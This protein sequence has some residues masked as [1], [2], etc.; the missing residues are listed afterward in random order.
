MLKIFS[1]FHHT[2]RLNFIINIVRLVY[3]S[4]LIIGVFFFSHDLAAQ[5]FTN[6]VEY[7]NYIV[8]EQVKVVSQNVNYLSYSVHSDDVRLVDEKRLDLIAQLLKSSQKLVSMGGYEG[9][10]RLRDEA[11]AVMDL[12]LE[13]FNVDL[14][15]IA[16]L[17]QSS[18]E[19]Y[20][21]METYF[22]TL[23]SVEAK[24]NQAG[25]RFDQAQKEFADEYNI[26]I[27]ETDQSL[28]DMLHQISMV[29][30]YT[31]DMYL[32]Y[33]K[34]SKKNAEL[35]DALESNDAKKVDMV[36]KE[37]AKEA[38]I[39]I[40]KATALGGFKDD[41]A[42]VE[43]TLDW[44]SFLKDLAEK[45]LVKVVRFLEMNQEK[46]GFNSQKEV[47]QYNSLVEF[48]NQTIQHYNSQSE[49]LNQTFNAAYE[50]LLKKHIPDVTEKLPK[51]D[52]I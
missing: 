25:E 46:E 3:L 17:K 24:L 14:K 7:N 30:A 47:D 28:S 44:A 43:A 50:S 9:N 5:S 8:N 27:V 51:G 10:T 21:A 40:E 37:L 39:G 26:Q 49:A 23:G 38:S 20:S 42:Y 29:N 1:I 32:I 15:N 31:R 16:S 12:Y 41:R 45:D 33:F 19:S 4:F 6:P 36:R 48:Y 34:I 11:T 13:A 22:K 52:R 18:Q 2:T 35:I